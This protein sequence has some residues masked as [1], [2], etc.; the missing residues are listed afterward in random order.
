MNL[1]IPSQPTARSYLGIKSST[2]LTRRQLPVGCHISQNLTAGNATEGRLRNFTSM[3][4]CFNNLR[5]SFL[6]CLASH[7][8]TYLH[9]QNTSLDSFNQCDGTFRCDATK[10]LTLRVS[11]RGQDERQYDRDQIFLGQHM[12]LLFLFHLV[13]VFRCRSI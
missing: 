5:P 10:G 13:D 6:T 8:A 9:I 4:G 3:H 12:S 1:F 7:P 11:Q 2:D